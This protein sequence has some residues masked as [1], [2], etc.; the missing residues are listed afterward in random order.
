MMHD[1]C[2]AGSPWLNVFPLVRWSEDTAYS[3]GS[4]HSIFPHQNNSELFYAALLHFKFVGN[5]SAKIEEAIRH[6]QYW[7]NS[8]EYRR[9][10]R[11]MR[12]HGGET[13]LDDA[14]SVKFL[15]AS[16]LI[17]EKLIQPI[18]WKCLPRAMFTPEEAESVGIQA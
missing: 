17:N 13:L 7:D 6:N 1:I 16:S 2:I 3:S 4:R 8:A 10:A 5:V 14:Y 18:D 11:W 15:G 12:C 9:Y